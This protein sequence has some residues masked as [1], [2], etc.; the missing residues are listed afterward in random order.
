MA[1][2][3]SVN[4]ATAALKA[5]KQ[6]A[7]KKSKTQL[8]QQRQEK[9]ARYNPARI[10]KQIEDLQGATRPNDKKRLEELEKQLRQVKKAR[11]NLGD[12][13]PR[14]RDGDGGH[15]GR[16][17]R[18]RG[19]GV[20]G[21]RRRDGQRV[22]DDSS[23]TDEDVRDIPMPG[24]TPPPIPR[25]PR[26]GQPDNPNDTPLGERERIAVPE[27]KERKTTYSAAPAIRDLRKEAI[28][29][30]MP[31]AV[32]QKLKQSRGQGKLLEPEEADRLE[33][34]GYGEPR[35]ALAVAQPEAV[36]ST[37]A[38]VTG[39]AKNL[40]EEERRFLEEINMGVA[41]N[42]AEMAAEK[43]VDATVE[44]AQHKMMAA[45][46]EDDMRGSRNQDELAEKVLHQ[47][48]MEEVEDEGT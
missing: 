34:E 42:D 6:K 36:H 18:G 8:V 4:P 5:S 1:K 45:E 26:R 37:L 16:G 24:D 38:P 7:I 12:A 17:D 13:A 21:K 44:E 11:E 48:E 14:Y 27:K 19:G 9:L 32:A 15:R 35:K 39:Q 41:D 3:K 43:A 47:V 23:D 25:R 29:S 2:D 46:V 31:S 30:F 28:S 20:L 33:K 10:E 22:E 40:D